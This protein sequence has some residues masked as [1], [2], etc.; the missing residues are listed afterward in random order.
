MNLVR[1]GQ[2]YR[3]F[4]NIEET[5]TW[6]KKYYS[7]LLALPREDELHKI[8]TYY[9]GSYY[10]WYNR[11]LRDYFPVDS[12][13]F[14]EIDSADVRENVIEIQRIIETLYK[15]SLPE[16]I[17]A[18]RFTHKAVIKSLCNGQVFHS[19][20]EFSDKAFFSTTLIHYLLKDFGWNNRCNCLLKL[21]LPKGLPGAY[22][23]I[24]KGWSCLN[25]QE[26][27]LPPNI[28]FRILKIHYFTY[29]LKIE[30]M[31]IHD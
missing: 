11:L 24:D 12:D 28:K 30:C 7:D 1:E 3:E 14:K 21:Y 20:T 23:S 19:G 4:E 16:N 31:A 15:Y 5:E 29:P 17:I 22:V 27:L 10:K 26:F 25:E 8:I 9:T 18:Y 13:R 6:A 2:V